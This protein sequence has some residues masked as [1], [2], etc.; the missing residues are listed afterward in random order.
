MLSKV[1]FLIDRIVSHLQCLW[2]GESDREESEKVEMKIVN[3]LYL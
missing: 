2:M 1:V 3:G